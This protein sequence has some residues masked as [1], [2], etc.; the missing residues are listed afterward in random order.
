MSQK[1]TRPLFFDDEVN[2]AFSNAKIIVD[3]AFSSYKKTKQTA[4]K[5]HITR[6]P[7]FNKLVIDEVKKILS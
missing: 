3:S 5:Q 2:I 6:D 7:E 1:K 4:D